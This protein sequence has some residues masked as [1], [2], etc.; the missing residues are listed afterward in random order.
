VSVSDG[1]AFKVDVGELNAEGSIIRFASSVW[2]SGLSRKRSEL[3]EVFLESVKFSSDRVREIL[4]D[5]V[6]DLPILEGDGRML[7]F[8]FIV[9]VQINLGDVIHAKGLA[10]Y[11][12]VDVHG[13][14]SSNFLHNVKCP[15][16]GATEKEVES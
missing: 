14:D 5:K 4:L 11:L 2:N 10:A 1:G 12:N 15:P 13:G 9:P 16:T 8:G 3:L 6:R 7:D